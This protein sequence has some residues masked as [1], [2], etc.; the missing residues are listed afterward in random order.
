[1]RNPSNLPQQITKRGLLWHVKWLFAC[2]AAAL[3]LSFLAALVS[4]P[5][6]GYVFLEWL[7]EPSGSIALLTTAVVMSPLIYRHLK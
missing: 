5:F 4:I 2:Y 7:F 3:V 1:M 6:M